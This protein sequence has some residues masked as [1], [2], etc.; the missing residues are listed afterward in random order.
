MCVCARVCVVIVVAILHV[1]RPSL[2][3]P[4][5]HLASRTSSVSA[6]VVESNI[7][8]IIKIILDFSLAVE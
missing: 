7:V 1:K 2:L 8:N 6:I 3:S 4:P 5:G